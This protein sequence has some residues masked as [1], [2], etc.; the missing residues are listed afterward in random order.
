MIKLAIGV[1]LGIGLA[2]T[3]PEQTADFSEFLRGKI[4]QGAQVVVDQ[5]KEQNLVDRLAN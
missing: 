4:N 3:F 1:V 5:T 2:T